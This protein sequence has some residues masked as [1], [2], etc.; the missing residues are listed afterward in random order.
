MEN[1][2]PIS[3]LIGGVLIGTGVVLLM[4]L[5]GRIAGISGIFGQLLLPRHGGIAW[6]AAYV[7]G[8]VLGALAWR[9]GGGA[10]QA[11]QLTDSTPVLIAGGLLV[12]I[13]VRLANGCTSGH[14]ICG[15]ARFSPRSIWATV[16]F[17]VAGF[18]TVFVVRH[19]IGGA[20]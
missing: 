10:P 20:A 2:T 5:D 8:S 11:L 13:G 3:A 16:T 7:A 6:R 1:F 9:L 14:G 15:I 4:W 17:M 18:A 12:G 19:L